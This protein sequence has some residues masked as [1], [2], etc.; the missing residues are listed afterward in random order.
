MCEHEM[1]V[2]EVFMEVFMDGPNQMYSIH[3][4]MELKDSY[5]SLQ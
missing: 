1:C 5:I 3:E 4:T 2:S